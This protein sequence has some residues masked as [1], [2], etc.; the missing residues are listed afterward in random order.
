MSCMQKQ[1]I[2]SEMS[3]ISIKYTHGD[4]L[5]SYPGF[6]RVQTKNLKERGEPGKVYHVRNE[7][8]ELNYKWAKE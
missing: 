4:C 1:N 2:Q 3:H 8:R 7:W 5:A 6:P